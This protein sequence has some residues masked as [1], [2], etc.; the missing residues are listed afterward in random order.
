M[1][2]DFRLPEGILLSTINLLFILFIFYK[3][4]ETVSYSYQLGNNGNS[5]EI[6]VPRCQTKVNLK[7]KSFYGQQSQDFI[8][9]I[10]YTM[11]KGIWLRK[12]PGL[13]GSLQCL[14]KGKLER[15]GVQGVK[16]EYSGVL[17][18]L[19]SSGQKEMTGWT[20]YGLIISSVCLP[21]LFY[22][23]PHY[24]SQRKQTGF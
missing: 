7:G 2:Q 23:S 19:P 5:P 16:Q 4:S 11:P 10:F 3:Q 21:F 14:I 6:Q 17:S 15:W 20:T 18:P 13:L 12:V 8:L 22:C 1:Y 9:T 24:S